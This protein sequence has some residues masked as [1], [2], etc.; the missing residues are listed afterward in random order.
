MKRP[1][2]LTALGLMTFLCLMWGLQQ[3]AM[4]LAAPA[5]DPMLQIGIRSSIAAILVFV[6]SRFAFRNRWQSGLF[7]GPGLLAGG[8]FAAEFLLV[9]EG[10]RW[11]TASHMAVFLYTAPIFAAIGL[12][13]AQEDERLSPFQWC[14]VAVTFAGVAA[15]FL[16]PELQGGSM[17]AAMLVGDLLGLAA[18]ISWGL[19]TV[20]IR[21]S[22]LAE[23]PAAQTLSYQLVTAAVSALVFCALTGRM[24]IDPR[25]ADWVNLG[26]QATVLCTVSFLIWFRLLQIYPSSR[27]GVLSFMTPVFGVAAGAL[28]LDEPLTLEFLFG[29]AMVLVGMIMVQAQD[30]MTA[31]ARRAAQCLTPC[32]EQS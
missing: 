9:A 12:Q 17:H 25:P 15:I 26:L 21:T 6:L 16:L 18:G 1:I 20:V 4:K 24:Q 13:L 10:L 19:T 30:L 31:R 11:T 5:F 28:L 29:G 22:R 32:P 7:F 27:L 2:D 14:G 3:S 8:L 23:A